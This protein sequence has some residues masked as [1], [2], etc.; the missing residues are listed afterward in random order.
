M[1]NTVSAAS[2]AFA[3]APARVPELELACTPP[4]SAACG[5]VASA[6]TPALEQYQSALND[7]GRMIG[8]AQQGKHFGPEDK[9]RLDKLLSEYDQR[10]DVSPEQKAAMKKIA[11]EFKASGGGQNER[12]DSND[13]ADFMGRLGGLL[14]AVPGGE[15][16]GRALQDFATKFRSAYDDSDGKFGKDDMAALGK[17][18]A[19]PEV[20]KLLDLAQGSFRGE[21]FNAADFGRFFAD[22]KITPETKPDRLDPPMLAC[23]TAP[24]AGAL[25]LSHHRPGTPA[26]PVPAFSPASAAASGDGALALNFTNNGTINLN[27]GNLNV[28]IPHAF[29]TEVDR[30]TA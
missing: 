20:D 9:A 4:P 7:F 2:A 12:V 22:M 17:A 3:G 16:F 27:I 8:E 28:G 19:R 25:A 5:T 14:R 21:Q 26:A 24:T 18:R 13:W 10:T 29:S 11:A 30:L 23:G 1:T 6:G 15:R